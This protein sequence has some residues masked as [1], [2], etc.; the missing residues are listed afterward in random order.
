MHITTQDRLR[1]IFDH[2]SMKKSK[3][4]NN[5]QHYETEELKIAEGFGLCQPLQTV[6]ADM[7]QYFSRTQEDLF[8]QRTAHF[9][10]LKWQ[11]LQKEN[12]LCSL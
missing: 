2:G 4:S 5:E 1:S 11:K 12:L 6:H 9:F 7:G 8:S 10:M 3:F